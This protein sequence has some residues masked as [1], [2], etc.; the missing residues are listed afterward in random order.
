MIVNNELERICKE[1][2]VAWLQVLAQHLSAWIDVRQRRALGE[3]QVGH[4][5][6][7]KWIHKRLGFPTLGAEQPNEQFVWQQIWSS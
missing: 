3:I 1:G 7:P 6:T 4:I 5:Q 2:V